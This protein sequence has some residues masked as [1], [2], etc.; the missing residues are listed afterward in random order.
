LQKIIDEDEYG[1]KCEERGRRETKKPL[2]HHFAALN[3][4]FETSTPRCE[5]TDLY[6]KPTW[7]S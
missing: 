1:Y 3:E 5:D 7:I 6:V 4:F 2:E